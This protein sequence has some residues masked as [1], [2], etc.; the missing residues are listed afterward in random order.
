MVK[1]AIVKKIKFDLALLPVIQNLASLG[2][3][4]ADI[5]MIIG[6]S[7]RKPGKF[8][9]QLKK[10][11]PDVAIALEVGRRLADIELVTTAF[12]AAVG[13]DYTEMTRDYKFV[14]IRDEETGELIRR[15]KTLVKEKKSDKKQRPDSAIL[16]MLLLSRLPDYFI[17]SKK[18]TLTQIMEADPTE[19]EIRRFAGKLM[20]LVNPTKVIEAQVID[21]E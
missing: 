19:D 1:N 21:S 14:E 15:E 20:A 6:Y 8:I 17:D 11:C 7:G 4:E 16:K 5:G 9:A 12:E 3:T 13:Y 18:V 2:K 10:E